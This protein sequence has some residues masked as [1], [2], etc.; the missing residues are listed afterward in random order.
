MRECGCARSTSRKG[1][2]NQQV[3]LMVRIVAADI[4]GLRD[5]SHSDIA[6]LV[7]H[8]RAAGNTGRKR[9]HCNATPRH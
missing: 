1:D 4:G 7:M 9:H 2:A 3:V 5:L 6:R 8:A